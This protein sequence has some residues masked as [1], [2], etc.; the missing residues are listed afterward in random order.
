MAPS[1]L[2][3]FIAVISNLSPRPI[4]SSLDRNDGALRDPGGRRLL[5]IE[6]AET[7]GLRGDGTEGRQTLLQF[8]STGAMRSVIRSKA[9]QTR[10]MQLVPR[11]SSI[12]LFISPN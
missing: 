6:Q 3:H 2:K 4:P 7:Q 11:K 12:A 9:W 1:R 5:A 8:D 10:Q